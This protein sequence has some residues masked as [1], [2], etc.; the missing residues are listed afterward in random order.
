MQ[1]KYDV[2]IVGGGTAG[3]ACAWSC[4]KLG[5]KTILIEKKP[6]LGGAI[7][8]QLV[9]PSMKTEHKNFNTTFF[10][11]LCK[12]AHAKNAQITYCDGNKGWFNPLLL[13]NILYDLLHDAG[14]EIVQEGLCISS[15]IYTDT[16][17]I[18]NNICEN[19]EILSIC[20]DEIYNHNIN[21]HDCIE[22][23]YIDNAQ[24][25]KTNKIFA[26]FFVDATGDAN[27]SEISGAKFLPFEKSQAM[28]LRFIMSGIDKKAF[29][30]WLTTLDADR[31]VTT[32]CEID[33]DIHL[34]TA[35]TWDS[36]QNWALKPI[37]DKAVNENVLKDSD[38]AYFQIFSIA[39][40]KDKI[41]FN[42]PRIL[43]DKDWSDMQPNDFNIL[44]A[45]AQETI[46]R[47]K[48]FCQK[49][50]V[51]F[52]NAQIYKIAD[53]FGIRESRRVK[54]LYTLTKE[55]IYEA[56][57]FENPVA[58]SNYPIDVHSVKKDDYTLD[59][60]Q[61]TY[62]IPLESLIVEGFSN[63]FVIGRCLGADFYAQ[64]A[65]RI[66]P[67][68]FSMGEGLAKYLHSL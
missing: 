30:D 4:A 42:C 8:S 57:T 38:R 60:V 66:Q 21:S 46:N 15:N 11:E 33:G 18:N 47:L 59:Y 10:D 13:N 52:K 53:E 45:E 43:S 32:A 64:A 54:C 2:A 12:A 49:Y 25:K 35:C 61:K 63:L 22:Q 40:E 6:Y 31:N 28:S 48:T 67:T 5:L 51:G 62:E 1:K 7:T 39:G 68:C 36:S 37:F 65:A 3:C 16:I 58:Y 26:K 24:I 20:Y 19:R 56:R 50:F 9:I 29:A 17:H 14:C 27:L 41:A 34:S 55:D 23:E 44:R